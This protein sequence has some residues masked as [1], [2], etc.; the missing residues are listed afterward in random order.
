AA[1]VDLDGS[2]T[3]ERAVPTDQIDPVL[4]EP[5]LLTR[6]GVVGDLEIAPCQRGVDVDG[7]RRGGLLRRMRR[8]ARAE[9]GLG[10]HARPVGALAADELALDERPPEPALCKRAGA[11]LPG[12]AGADHDHVVV[13]H[14]PPPRFAGVSWIDDFYRRPASGGN[15]LRPSA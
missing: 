14:L 6:V 9:Q 3:G 15:E 4:G 5:A 12:R 13:E 10:G 7:G 1:A 2:G 8:P 11:V